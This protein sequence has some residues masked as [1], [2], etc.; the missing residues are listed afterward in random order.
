MGFRYKKDCN[1]QSIQV[2]Y[3]DRELMKERIGKYDE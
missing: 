1:F 3:Y 2:K